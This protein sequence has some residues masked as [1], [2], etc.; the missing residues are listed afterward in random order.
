MIFPFIVFYLKSIT[1]IQKIGGCPDS[2]PK[3][4]L[5]AATMFTSFYFVKKQKYQVPFTNKP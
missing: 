5:P 4:F 3:R 2:P 1:V